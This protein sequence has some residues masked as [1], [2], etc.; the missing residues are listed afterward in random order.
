MQLSKTRVD[1]WPKKAMLD[2]QGRDALAP[3]HKGQSA[4][5]QQ[6]SGPAIEDEGCS[7]KAGKEEQK[8]RN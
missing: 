5:K 3:E 2:G 6:S 1:K 4:A 8:N 7:Q